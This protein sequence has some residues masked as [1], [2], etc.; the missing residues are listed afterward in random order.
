[1]GARVRVVILRSELHAF[2]RMSMLVERD[3]VGVPVAAVAE[4]QS[5]A[6]G[7]R[8]GNSS[9]LSRAAPASAKAKT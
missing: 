6:E 1:M 8:L 2:V 4:N 5:R 9:T 3:G 7:V